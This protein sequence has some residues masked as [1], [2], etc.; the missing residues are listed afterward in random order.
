MN[1]IPK[2][3]NSWE[4]TQTVFGY[5]GLGLT[6]GKKVQPELSWQLVYQIIMDI[7]RQIGGVFAKW[8]GS[9][10][11]VDSVHFDQI[12]FAFGH[13]SS[14]FDCDIFV[15]GSVKIRGMLATVFVAKTISKS[16]LPNK[17]YDKIWQMDFFSFS[18]SVTSMRIETVYNVFIK[19][20]NVAGG[21]T[22]K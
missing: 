21:K 7:F 20:S 5:R 18:A 4:Q 2:G 9:S 13:F 15:V 1:W 19:K 8:I 12:E 3:I 16:R 17:M 14:L 11:H 10:C 22:C 6:E